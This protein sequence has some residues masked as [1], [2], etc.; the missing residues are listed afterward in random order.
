[1][2]QTFAD[3]AVIAIE[4]VRLFNETKEA[5]ERQTATSEILRIIS[6][7]P[8]DV[9]PVLDAIARCSVELCD[10]YFA[11]VFL[12]E[13][14]MVHWRASHNVPPEANALMRSTYPLATN[15]DEFI[16]RIVR[17][18]QVLVLEDA[19]DPDLALHGHN[20]ARAIGHRSWVAVP[21]LREGSA[22]GVLAVSRREV[23]SFSE[24][25]I[26][27]LKI[28]ADQAVIAIE[29]VRLFTELQASNREL[30]TALDKQTATSEILRVISQSQMDV[31]PVFDA[32]VHS[33][34]RL[35][36][37]YS[38]T[39]NRIEGDQIELAAITSTDDAGNA[40]LMA[41]YPQSLYSE[42]TPAQAIR[43]RAPLNIANAQ[44]DPRLPEAQRAAARARGYRS[45]VVMPL[46]RQAEAIGAL[47]VTRR[48]PGGFTDD[49][50]A[51]LQ[52]FADQAVIAIE[53]VRLFTELQEKNEALTQAHA[54]VT[55]SLEQQT[56]MSDI[57]KVIASSSTDLAP[58]FDTICQSA[59]RLCGAYGGLITSFDGTLVHLAA[60]SSPNPDANEHVRREYPRRPDVTAAR[61]RAILERA[62]VHIPDTD[63]DS[64]Y[65]RQVAREFGYRRFAQRAAL[66][67]LSYR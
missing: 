27:L 39:L 67:A 33:A 59:I 29:N 10:A 51:L 17:E 30:T 5:L 7:S 6:S 48:E 41:A 53:N 57:L 2:L 62:V 31:Q 44:T 65:T 54:Q 11:N 32:I 38:S 49:E 18:Q 45:Q 43:D 8:T 14:G 26:D 46:L 3:Q 34:V 16:P 50:I 60:V 13:G 61:D 21:L 47:G 20:R 1:L 55:E 24:R 28:F 36:G 56:A 12:V 25:Q 42:W 19:Q 40:A 4:N 22:I 23:K 35:L 37:A 9:Q 52:T 63:A 15:A 66:S 58:V 64:E